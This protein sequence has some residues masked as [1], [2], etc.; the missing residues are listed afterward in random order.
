MSDPVTN[1]D[2]EDVLSSIR[3]LVSEEPT[4][5]KKRKSVAEAV[6]ERFVLTPALRIAESQDPKPRDEEPRES[7]P[8]MHDEGRQA[9]ESETPSGTKTFQ[10][11]TFSVSTESST[12]SEPDS[13]NAPGE[14][15]ALAQESDEAEKQAD[16]NAAAFMEQDDPASDHRTTLEQ[17]IAEL[18]AALQ[19]SPE[20]WEP[21]GSEVADRTDKSSF[22]FDE[23]EDAELAS[24]GT[25]LDAEVGSQA[26]KD[27]EQDAAGI[28]LEDAQ[29]LDPLQASPMESPGTE[30]D[31]VLILDAARIESDAG[32]IPDTTDQFEQAVD[33]TLADRRSET[34]A[35]ADDEQHQTTND[36]DSVHDA[37]FEAAL[38]SI[39]SEQRQ[40][41]T[42]DGFD[43]QNS[44]MD[45]ADHTAKRG[46]DAESESESEDSVAGFDIFADE[47]LLDEEALREMVAQI[48]RQELQGVLG[49]RITRNVRRLVRREIQRAMAVRELD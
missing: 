33:F 5:P 21:D 34:S 16:S 27:F 7:E 9:T 30:P 29:T 13:T 37:L 38:D 14:V 17:R 19:Q 15:V 4:G 41:E 31:G 12:S 20:E 40:P 22:S 46:A 1:A 32:A 42:D 3:R 39:V 11:N 25:D 43:T 6:R 47:A 45:A 28:H 2:I 36:P 10:Y 49:E 44:K 48:V 8:E 23:V 24:D 35:E 18:E 26:E